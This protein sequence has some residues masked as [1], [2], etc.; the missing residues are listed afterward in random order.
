MKP[1]GWVSRLRSGVAWSGVS[2]G[3]S[4]GATLLAQMLVANL[5][6]R[7]T[8][9]RYAVLQST[10]VTAAGLAQ[11]CGGVA[12]R[13]FASE[14]GRTDPPKCGR[15][16]ARILA[17]AAAASMAGAVLVALAAEPILRVAT[18]GAAPDQAA[19]LRAGSAYVVFSAIAGSLAGMLAGFERYRPVLA[20][21]AAGFVAQVGLVWLLSG[22]LGLA[23]ATTGLV[24]GSAASALLLAALSAREL[25]ALGVRL[26][27]G[28]G[29][30]EGRAVLHFVLPGA[31]IAFWSAPSAWVSMMFLARR[32][33]GGTEMALYSAAHGLRLLA[34]FVP[35]LL[36]GVA[37]SVLGERKGSGD[38]E[39]YARVFRG[40]LLMNGGYAL[41]AAAFLS[42]G[43]PALLKLYGEGFEGARA[44]LRILAG[45]VIAETLALTVYLLVQ[46]RG[47]LWRSLLWVNVPLGLAQMLASCAWSDRWGASG[48][49]SAYG[50]SW[51]VALLMI[52]GLVLG[53]G[54]TSAEP[55]EA[56][57]P[58]G[59]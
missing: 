43:A 29:R 6:G 35:V 30:E 32:P 16:L 40:V 7:E 57:P 24:A 50:L 54:R 59:G 27:L 15:I 39:G 44:P 42:A 19:A 14:W 8:L 58:I 36:N 31:L 45:A 10:L 22:S 37:L 41:A 53:R 56:A 21:H 38:R 52:I 13:K 48:L 47:D 49:A 46:S 9:G 26:S 1:A 12:C 2:A 20:A 23:G 5:A 51:S 3:L 18:G 11:V 34:M 55:R 33:D 17:S 28:G 25:R 4:Q